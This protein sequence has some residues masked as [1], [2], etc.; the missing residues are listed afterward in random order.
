KTQEQFIL[1]VTTS[2]VGKRAS[3]YEYRVT[4][5]GGKGLIAHKLVGDARIVASFPVLDQEE[6]LLVTDKGQLIRTAIDQIRIAGRATQGVILINVSDD[7]H[8]VAAERLEALGGD[9]GEAGEGEG[10]GK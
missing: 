8:V 3:A 10:T 9:T 4:N 2:G 1:T 6:L 5:R 7:E